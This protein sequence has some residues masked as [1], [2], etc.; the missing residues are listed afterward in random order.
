MMDILY[1]HLADRYIVAWKGGVIILD[2]YIV[3]IFI[4]VLKMAAICSSNSWYPLVTLH[5]SITQN[6]APPWSCMV[7]VSFVVLFFFVEVIVVS[8][9]L[10]VHANN[11]YLSQAFRTLDIIPFLCTCPKVNFGCLCLS[12]HSLFCSCMVE[13]KFPVLLKLVFVSAMIY[14][15]LWDLVGWL[16]CMPLGCVT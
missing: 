12:C 1:N 2:E 3:Y 16:I 7:L 9:T 14:C 11:N 6:T 8:V 5:S 13:S 10:I 15:L 4:S